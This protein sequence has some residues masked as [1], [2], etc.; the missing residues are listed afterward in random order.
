[1]DFDPGICATSS[2]DVAIFNSINVVH[3]GSHDGKASEKSFCDS[4]GDM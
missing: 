1:M 2:K 4:D 3:A